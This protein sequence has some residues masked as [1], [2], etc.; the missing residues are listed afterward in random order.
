VAANVR[1]LWREATHREHRYAASV[2]AN[3]AAARRFRD[4]SA[5]ALYEE[6]IRT[7][8]WWDHVDDAAHRVG[9]L[10][11]DHRPEMSPI[12]LRWAEDP[13]RWIRRSAIIC[14]L[15][16]RARTDTALLAST[17]SANETDP[18]FFVRKAIGWALR[19]YAKTD[20]LWVRRFIAGRD[21]SPL[22]RREALRRLL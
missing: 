8:A 15:G 19:E 16:H 12:V 2:L 22:S 6:M 18:D 14:Q 11:L 5:L 13:D 17:I 9:D 10:L 7:G 1:T 20:P 21:L 3:T 4:L